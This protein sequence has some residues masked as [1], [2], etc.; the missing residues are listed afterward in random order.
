[1]AAPWTWPIPQK[2]T[3]P[4]GDRAPNGFERV[5]QALFRSSANGT[6]ALWAAHLDKYALVNSRWPNGVVPSLRKGMLYLADPVDPRATKST[7]CIYTGSV[8]FIADSFTL[9]R[10]LPDGSA[11]IRCNCVTTS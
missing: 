9:S 11:A 3:K 10:L 4:L 1:M 6:Y 7:S 5:P 2:T 8:T